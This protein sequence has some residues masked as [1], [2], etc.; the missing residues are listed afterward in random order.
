M[1][2]IH[3]PHRDIA[4]NGVNLSPNLD[5]RGAR[6]STRAGT[7]QRSTWPPL[8]FVYRS[9]KFSSFSTLTRPAYLSYTRVLGIHPLVL[10]E[11]NGREFIESSQ[12]K[13]LDLFEENRI[14]HLFYVGG[15]TNKCIMNRP[16]GIRAMATLGFNT[17]LLRDATYAIETPETRESGQITEGSILEVEINHGFSALAAELTREFLQMQ[18]PAHKLPDQGASD[19]PEVRGVGLNRLCES[20]GDSTT[21]GGSEAERLTKTSTSNAPP[22]S[23]ARTTR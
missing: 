18:T 19:R 9:S 16:V 21:D 12:A 8:D 20:T 6:S 22:R 1:L 13:V 4:W 14:L 3:S 2:V 17:I 15:A 7:D 23:S 11:K 5:L 10:P